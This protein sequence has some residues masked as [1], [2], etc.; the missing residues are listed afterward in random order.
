MI[1]NLGN[2]SD[3]LLDRILRK[4]EAFAGCGPSWTDTCILEPG[5]IT[6]GC[7]T[8]MEC[9]GRLYCTPCGKC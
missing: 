6:Y 9:S 8:C 5:K 7:R 2:L 3:R 1:S 4:G